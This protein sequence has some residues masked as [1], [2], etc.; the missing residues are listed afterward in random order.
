MAVLVLFPVDF[1]IFW[2]FG[3]GEVQT[4]FVYFGVTFGDVVDVFWIVLLSLWLDIWGCFLGWQGILA[5]SE[6]GSCL[7]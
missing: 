5:F 2:G 6:R 7:L 4:G 3:G 1:V